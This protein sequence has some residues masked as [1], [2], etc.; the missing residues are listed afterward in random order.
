VSLLDT[1][2][3]LVDLG[4]AKAT[5]NISGTKDD[6]LLESCINRAS[7]WCESLCG[8]PLKERTFSAIRLQGPRSTKLYL[9]API[10]VTG[11]SG[12]LTVSVDEIAQTVWRT[13][14]DGDPQ[15][16]DVMVASDDP[17]DPTGLRNHLFR[18][19]RWD[20]AAA[21]GWEGNGRSPFVQP[22]NVL[23]TY[24]GGF[25]PVP[26]DLQQACLDLLQKLF[27][28]A[29]KQLGEVVS[30]SGPSGAVQLLDTAIPRR[31]A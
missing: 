30:V 26:A 12:T 2:I 25:N 31:A 3:S 10:K 22:N 14:A 27:R 6:G 11:T 5:L 21:W 23:L 16:K 9:A 7:A 8:R 20:S 1:T 18:S 28:D 29:Q 19:A 13:E 24:T 15:A 17:H 4:A